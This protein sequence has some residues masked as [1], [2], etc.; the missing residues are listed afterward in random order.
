MGQIELKDDIRPKN[1]EDV[2]LR[3]SGYLIDFEKISGW[4]NVSIEKQKVK[5]KKGEIIETDLHTFSISYDGIKLEI[6]FADVR[7][8]N[9]VRDEAIKICIDWNRKM[10]KIVSTY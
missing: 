6:Y 7:A 2:Y 9:A 1:I 5:N 10:K 3:V 8:A 4:S